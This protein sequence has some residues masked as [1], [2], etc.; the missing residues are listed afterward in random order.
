MSDDR[1]IDP[2]ERIRQA[3]ERTEEFRKEREQNPKK[4]A[5]FHPAQVIV[6]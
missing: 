5:L 3:V 2:N 6:S 4:F 1:D